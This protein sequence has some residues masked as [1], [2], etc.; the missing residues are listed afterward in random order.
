VLKVA[1]ERLI[2][3]VQPGQHVLQDVGMDR[4]IL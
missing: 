4:R 2:G 1:E 3:L